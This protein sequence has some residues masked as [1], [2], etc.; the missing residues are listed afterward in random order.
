MVSYC[1]NI[2][3]FSTTNKAHFI[4]HNNRVSHKTATNLQEIQR[5]EEE[6]RQLRRDKDETKLELK[7]YGMLTDSLKREIE[8][9]K[10]IVK[11]LS[12]KS[13]I[14]NNTNTINNFIFQPIIFSDVSFDQL[15]PSIPALLQDSHSFYQNIYDHLLADAIG[16]PKVKCTDRSRQIVKWKDERGEMFKDAKLQRF[17]KTFRHQ[18]NEP[19]QK[20]ESAIWSDST[21][22]CHIPRA[23]Y[24]LKLRNSE[25]VRFIVNKTYAQK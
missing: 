7:H 18:Y 6:N 17:T 12:S 24:D 3:D 13:T 8:N 21:N 4:R 10:S 22:N 19:I 1:C 20:V 5:L 23:L 11:D 2:C 14:T 9:L 25:F 16:I 15:L